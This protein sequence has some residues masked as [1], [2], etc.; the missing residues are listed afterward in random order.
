VRRAHVDRGYRGHGV[1]REG[2]QV[3]VSLIRGIVSPTIRR[4]VRRRNG[5]APCSVT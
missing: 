1:L 5:I 4:E 2:L 3:V